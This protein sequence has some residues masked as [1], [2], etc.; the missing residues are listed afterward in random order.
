MSEGPTHFKNE[1]LCLLAKVIHS[2]HHFTHPYF[3]W[4]NGAI[5]SIGKEFL[6]VARALLS[7]L[8]LRQY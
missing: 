1:T 3:P 8:Q 4:N 2:T 7:E 5:E 6:L